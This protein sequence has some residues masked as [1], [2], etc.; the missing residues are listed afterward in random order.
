MAAIDDVTLLA[1]A[2]YTKPK[3]KGRPRAILTCVAQNTKGDLTDAERRHWAFVKGFGKG[4]FSRESGLKEM[5]TVWKDF[6]PTFNRRPLVTVAREYIITD[7]TILPITYRHGMARLDQ[8]EAGKRQVWQ[9]K[10][11][12]KTDEF[13]L[14]S[15]S[16]D[17]NS[18]NPENFAVLEWKGLE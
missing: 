4:T 8:M 1:M 13:I 16:E 5:P 10:V 11:A 14:R 3:E 6:K 17:F 7:V 15:R 12:D 2:V 9:D 18:D